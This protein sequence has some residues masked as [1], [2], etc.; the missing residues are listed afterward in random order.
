MMMLEN[1]KPVKE[2]VEHSAGDQAAS[3]SLKLLNDTRNLNLTPTKDS[4]VPQGLLPKFELFDKGLQNGKALENLP[5]PPENC[6]ELVRDLGKAL[7]SGDAT[8]IQKILKGVKTAEDMKNLQDAVDYLN[9]TSKDVKISLSNDHN[10]G[11]EPKPVIKIHSSDYTPNIGC[12]SGNSSY[13]VRITSDEASAVYNSGMGFVPTRD[14]PVDTKEALKS[15]KGKFESDGLPSRLP[16]ER[17]IPGNSIPRDF[18]PLQNYP[19][20]S[21]AH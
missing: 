17:I 16:S 11:F 12:G 20:A 14:K 18:V 1:E 4:S 5:P 3:C 6:R 7:L 9:K 8:Q 10:P 13:D 15:I 21:K 2:N 19:P